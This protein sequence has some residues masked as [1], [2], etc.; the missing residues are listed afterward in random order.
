MPI[1]ENFASLFSLIAA[2]EGTSKSPDAD[3]I[4]RFI[5]EYMIASMIDINESVLEF[6]FDV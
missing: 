2:H 6:D 5:S 4:K 1:L 3:T